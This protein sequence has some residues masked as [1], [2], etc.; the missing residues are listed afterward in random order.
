MPFA[1]F[2]S[3]AHRLARLEPGFHGVRAVGDVAYLPDLVRLGLALREGDR[4]GQQ[5]AVDDVIDDARGQRLRRRDR[6]AVGAHLER[7]LRAGQ[8][9]QPLRAAGAE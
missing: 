3:E 5:I 2:L 4:A 6:L 8:T 7:H 9:R 1:V